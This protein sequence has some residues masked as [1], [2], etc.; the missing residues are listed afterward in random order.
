MTICVMPT[1]IEDRRIMVKERTNGVYR[2]W[3]YS[4]SNFIISIP[5]TLV[6]A[7]CAGS[8]LF[9]LVDF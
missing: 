5:F 8:I 3:V 7:L 4:L 2:L 9:A 1:Y 6:L